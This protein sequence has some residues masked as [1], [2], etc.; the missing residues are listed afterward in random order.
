MKMSKFVM[1]AVV[2]AAIGVGTASAKADSNLI[3][4]GGF[5]TGDFTSWTRTGVYPAEAGNIHGGSYAAGF[6][7][8]DQQISQSVVTVPGH[9]YQIDYWLLYKNGSGAD[10][11]TIW[12]GNT[13]SDVPK[14]SPFPYTQYT[15]E[16]AATAASTV[17]EFAV[18]H[19]TAFGVVG[20]TFVL[21]DVSVT[22]LSAAP[23]PTSLGLLALGGIGLLARRRRT[24]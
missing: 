3:T 2:A 16:E 21:D 18:P 13:I 12:D 24:P 19:G 15:F 17:L 7:S 4:N 20:D 9:T 8:T 1:G 22:D 14:A 11:H 23:E 5:E 10:L 6:D